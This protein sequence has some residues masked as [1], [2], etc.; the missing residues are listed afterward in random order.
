MAP[1]G[2]VQSHLQISRIEG[3][4]AFDGLFAV[5]DELIK[6]TVKNREAIRVAFVHQLVGGVEN[7]LDIGL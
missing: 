1:H 6:S 2:E 5:K 3:P 7:L 4:T